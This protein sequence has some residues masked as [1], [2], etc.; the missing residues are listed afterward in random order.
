MFRDIHKK[1]ENIPIEY[2]KLSL[3]IALERADMN[4]DW[5]IYKILYSYAPEF[6]SNHLKITGFIFDYNYK[7]LSEQQINSLFSV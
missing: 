4:E 7:N 3:H 5:E 2:R 1:N 6:L